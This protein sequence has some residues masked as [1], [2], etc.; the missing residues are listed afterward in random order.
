VQDVR[1]TVVVGMQ[2]TPSAKRL[3]RNAAQP[4]I[5]QQTEQKKHCINFQIFGSKKLAAMQ[6]NC[7]KIAALLSLLKEARR[8]ARR[9]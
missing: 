1:H 2:T 5:K 9:Y 7:C 3:T 4:P 8:H 6:Q